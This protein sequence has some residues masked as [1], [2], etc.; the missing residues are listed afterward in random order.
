MRFK[1]AELDFEEFLSQFMPTGVGGDFPS[2]LA[3]EVYPSDQTV[4]LPV[5]TAEAYL[6]SSGVYTARMNGHDHSL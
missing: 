4:W 6:R 2:D 3:D 5:G 1:C